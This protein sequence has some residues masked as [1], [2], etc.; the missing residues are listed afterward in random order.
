MNK[1][2]IQSDKEFA[3]QDKQL[4]KIPY[5]NIDKTICGCGLTTVAIESEENVIIAMP[6]VPLV[7]NKVEQ[8][9]N[10]RSKYT[11]FPVY[12]KVTESDIDD[13]I[14]ECRKN[15][16][17]IKI[18]TTYDG[19]RKVEKYLS[20][21]R[22]IIDESNQILSLTKD[23]QRKDNIIKMLEIAEKNKDTL[24]LISATP[25]ELKYMPKWIGDIEQVKIEWKNTTKSV[26]I[27]LERTY[28]F[29]SLRE[30]IIKPLEENKTITLAE[31]TFSSIIV[32]L[33]SVEQITK[34][35]KDCNLNKEDCKIICGDSL[36]NDLKIS[37]IERYRVED[38]FRYLFITKSGFSGMDIESEDAMTV[39]VSNTSREWQMVDVLTDLKQAVSR[40]RLKSNPNYGYY[41]YIY[42]QSIFE[43]S[44]EELINK[45]ET[46]RDRIQKGINIYENA[47]ITG[48]KE[49]F[50]VN[51]D[52]TA[53]T[54]YN[55][56]RDEYVLN[57]SA[58][59][60]DMYYILET[61]KQ[62][63]KGFDI[64]GTFNEVLEVQKV[65]LPASITF[66][67]LVEFFNQN[68]VEGEVD[69]NIYIN[70]TE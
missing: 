38:K 48:N 56:D 39:V 21:C 7:I 26:P 58:F 59:N 64:K 16:Q 6:T 20:V 43:Y 9:P 8:Y 52:F 41:I 12:A 54:I 30:E 66:S 13:Y 18:I 33:N 23:R 5:G 67:D 27:L 22:L 55:K 35:I 15:K 46:K 63:T 62:Y 31:K 1:I 11:L 4:Q 14:S 50:M 45:L 70:K 68:N 34:L 47:K 61:K 19:V 17:P 51:A 2:L 37:G 60:A 40:Q 57:E 32:F 28:P 65:D 36:K 10:E 24:S 44:E 69:W 53:Y 25:I 49:G 3:S 29:K 42:N